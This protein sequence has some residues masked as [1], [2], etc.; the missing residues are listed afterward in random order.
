MFADLASDF[1]GLK[2]NSLRN[3]NLAGEVTWPTPAIVRILTPVVCTK[4]RWF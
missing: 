4:T 1:N 3:L 2:I